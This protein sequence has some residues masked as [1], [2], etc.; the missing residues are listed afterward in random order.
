MSVDARPE[1]PERLSGPR[2]GPDGRTFPWG[3]ID[4]T[5]EVGEYQIVQ[6]R[7]DMSNSSQPKYWHEHGQTQFHPY[8]NGR[9]TSCSYASLDSAL[10][11]VI[12]YRRE[13]PNG[14]AAHYFDRM[15]LPSVDR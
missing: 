3:P 6:F 8:I 5:H 10:V 15:T 11:G 7:R 4:A 14:Q 2:I 13:G 9:D 12:A 1:P